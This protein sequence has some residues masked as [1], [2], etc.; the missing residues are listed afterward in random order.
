MKSS[1]LLNCV[2]S[3]QGKGW[4]IEAEL[5]MLVEVEALSSLDDV[6]K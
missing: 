4:V 6:I 3:N 5:K 1:S 2:L